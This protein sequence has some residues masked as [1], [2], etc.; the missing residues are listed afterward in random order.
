MAATETKRDCNVKR[1]PLWEDLSEFI[2]TPIVNL[3]PSYL[4]AKMRA[5]LRS[6]LIS[7]LNSRCLPMNKRVTEKNEGMGKF[8]Q[9]AAEVAP[10]NYYFTQRF[11]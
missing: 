7:P 10:L 5:D 2:L 4:S 8:S 9:D 11:L 6:A 1:T 3:D